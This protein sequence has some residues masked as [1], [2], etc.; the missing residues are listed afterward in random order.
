MDLLFSTL[1]IKRLAY[2]ILVALAVYW[3]KSSS[4][5]P[6]VCW[7]VWT[8]FLLSWVTAGDSFKRRLNMIVITGLITGFVS[9]LVGSLVASPLLLTLILFFITFICVSIGEL[10]PKYFMQTC[11]VIVFAILS[12]HFSIPVSENSDRFIFICLGVAIAAVLQM[13]FYPYFIRNE[14]QPYII[15]S[16]RRLRKLNKEIFSC[17]LDAEYADN[18]YLY[19]RRLHISKNA[20]LHSLSRLRE[21]TKLA[22]TKLSD[23]EK[24]SHDRWLNQLDSLFENILDYSQLRWRITDYT[25][26][27]VCREELISLAKESDKCLAAVVAHVKQKKYFTSI[28]K[29]NQSINQF[30]TNYH[31]VLQVAS[32]E[33]LVFLLF[34]D[35]LNAFSK[36]VTALYESAIPTSS[37]LF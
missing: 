16:L 19:E 30:E 22:E 2:L 6:E 1:S 29:L 28:D 26:F 25:T 27:S 5:N 10:H 3:I 17:F 24:E 7:L 33:P 37:H 36:K 31:Q 13:V 35:S 18:I 11:I 15:I 9:F 32:A 34:I 8:A 21:I 12:G 23:I 14:L 20:F 4:S